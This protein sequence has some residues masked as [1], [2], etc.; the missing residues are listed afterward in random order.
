MRHLSPIRGVFLTS[1]Y[2]SR[3]PCC[4]LAGLKVLSGL[5]MK[6]DDHRELFIFDFT[7]ARPRVLCAL[8]MLFGPFT[9]GGVLVQAVARCFSL[10][11]R[12]GRR[13]DGL[14]AT[15]P[16]CWGG[17]LFLAFFVTKQVHSYKNGNPL[18]VC[19]AT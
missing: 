3:S 9:G 4:I 17:G 19:G 7:T 14:F 8:A 1:C 13:I 12:N 10:W 18:L 15:R 11:A 2:G 5:V 6:S 16:F